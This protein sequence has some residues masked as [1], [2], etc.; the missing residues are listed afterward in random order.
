MERIS[1][2]RLTQERLDFKKNRIHGFYAKPSKNSDGTMNMY[3]WECKFPGPTD[4]PWEGGYYDLIFEFPEDY[5]SSPPKAKFKD[6][7]FHPN[8]YPSGTVCLSILNDEE[9]WRPTL[10]VLDVSFKINII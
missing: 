1:L 6:K 2:E 9:D 8:V 5:P 10:K 3:K 7:L 4:S